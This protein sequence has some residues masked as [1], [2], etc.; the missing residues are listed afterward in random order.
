MSDAPGQQPWQ[1][2][3]SQQNPQNQQDPRSSQNQQDPRYSP[4]YQSQHPQAQQPYPG[5]GGYADP[6]KGTNPGVSTS[7][8]FVWVLVLLPLVQLIGLAFWDVGDYLERTATITPG[9]YQSPF[10]PGYL[11][12]LGIGLLVYA[13]TVVFA[14]LDHRALTAR[15]IV[16]PFPWPWA[17]LTVVYVVGRSVVVKRR[18]GGGLAPL[19]LFI[20]VYL[21]TIVVAFSVFIVAFAEFVR[22]MPSLPT[23]P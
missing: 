2:P 1:N 11:A 5:P 6:L 15:G 12:Y 10:T 17:F 19:W 3:R 4:P 22:T 21:I 14:W 13:L 20:A 8:P 23:A 9:V 18:T 7:T 16:K